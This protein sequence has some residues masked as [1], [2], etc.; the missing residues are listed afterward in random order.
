MYKKIIAILLCLCIVS[1][2]FSG[3]AATNPTV[4]LSNHHAE[5]GE[6]VEMTLA[7]DGC[8]G[9][10]N[11]GLEIGYDSRYLKLIE[12]VDN[13][14]VGAT[15]ITAQDI[16]KNPYNIGWDS[17]ENKYFNGNLATV[18]FMVYDDAPDGDYIVTVDY[19]KGRDGKYKDGYA[20]NYD[21]NDKPLGLTYQAGCIVVENNDEP[22]PDV[23][24]NPGDGDETEK[25]PVTVSVVG[26]DGYAGDTVDV[27]LDISN[28]TG[29]AN[30]GLEIDYDSSVLTLVEVNEN[31]AVG[32]TLT[33]AQY[34]DTRPYNLSWDSVSNVTH[35]GNLAT[36]TFKIAQDAKAGDYPVSVSYYKGRNGNY[37]DGISV[38]YDENENPLT[39]KYVDGVVTV[40]DA[41]SDNP[42]NNVRVEFIS[43][44][45]IYAIGEAFEVDVWLYADDYAIRIYEDEY[46]IKGFDNTTAGT[47]EVVV[48]YGGYS[49]TF[50]VEVEEDK[51]TEV[52]ATYV[53]QALATEG[54]KIA[55][56]GYSEVKAGT[57]MKFAISAKEGYH[58][59]SVTVNKEQVN[60]TDGYVEI[61][62]TQNT[63]VE[64]LAE[65][66]K[67]SVSAEPAINGRIELSA[68]SVS[69][70]DNCSARIVAD[71]GYI[72]SDVFVDGKSVGVCK[73][74]TFSDVKENHTISATF[75][76]VITTFEI[77]AKAGKGG[78]IY[79]A[80]SI[81]N[82]GTDA[83]FTI[84]A[85]YGYHVDYVSVNGEQI[86]ITENEVLLE[87][88]T[89]TK[90]ISVVFAKDVYL[91]SVTDPEGAQLSVEYQGQTAKQQSVAFGDSVNI[92]VD[93]Q[94]GYKLNTLYVN[95]SP[96]KV[97][98]IDGKLI[99]SAQITGDTVV[100]ARCGLTLVSEFNNLVKQ[101]GLAADI[102]AANA[103][104]KLDIFKELARKYEELSSEEKRAC[105]SAYATILSAISRA[106][107]YIELNETNIIERI[108]ALPDAETVNS[109]NYESFREA[110][111]SIYAEYEKLTALSKSLIDYN[112]VA[113]LIRLREK[114]EQLDKQMQ[115]AINYLYRLIDSVPTEIIDANT[116]SNAYSAL[117]L[118][119]DT[120]YSMSEQEKKNVSDAKL[121]E[122][123]EKHGK[124]A[125]QVQKIYVTP[126]TGKVLRASPVVIS[127]SFEDAEAKRVIIH[128]LMDEYHALPDFVSE[129]IP[130]STIRKLNSLYESASIKIETA[131]N[132]IPVLINGDFD[133][134]TDV[135]ITDPEFEV[136]VVTETTGLS[137]YQAIDLKLL[138]NEQAAQP[139]SKIRVK[140]EISKE[141][142]EADVGVVY[143]D[144]NDNIFDVQGEVAEEDGKYYVAFFVDHFSKFAIIYD[145]A[146]TEG[147]NIKFDNEFAQIG[148]YIT[149]TTEG[150]V[151]ASNYIMFMA[152]Y[153]NEGKATFIEMGTESVSATIPED[154][155]SIKAM[156]WDKNL[157]PATEAAILT[158]SE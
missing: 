25:T 43:N 16:F 51:E 151:N 105:T 54:V 74:Y 122:L 97:R 92:V 118:A 28:N 57:V 71:D 35:N 143:V 53:V 13:A 50:V 130:S 145:E 37:T 41:I 6:I 7:L 38:N 56:S 30:L 114:I 98:K 158:I 77:S 66:K 141:L 106:N 88:V 93:V 156:F 49:K 24:G 27:N 18:R 9:F 112:Y 148:D 129:Q 96:V 63:V 2:L 17:A 102:N 144:D 72:I 60:I 147:I 10:V 149:A 5:A 123:M 31:D 113:K 65:K 21:E 67:Y 109:S 135:V 150:V 33:T 34:I 124:V 133:E 68:N 127:D 90:E 95:N 153:S 44:K 47:Y 70:G 22:N 64:A 80:R 81:V 117:M 125:T 15:C 12:V 84:K 116:L 19:Y 59:K 119:E 36:L 83:K 100:Y 94:N 76:K 45:T 32:A 146:A 137:V 115:G 8:N 46:Q 82:S 142:S 40:S 26:A 140:M 132:N 3:V 52:I 110:T 104:E 78:R 48:S 62:V 152:G 1:G 99:Y 107:A 61:A 23:G 79:P 111:D 121:D 29:F 69:Y 58:V 157:G 87:N 91:V 136:D 14:A 103:S 134:E 108:Y 101:A 39:M 55:P 11:L 4:S 86:A 154:T 128:A 89:E 42:E 126:F 155:A 138:S 131:V 20:V 85:D 139:L 75:E 120:Y 73:T